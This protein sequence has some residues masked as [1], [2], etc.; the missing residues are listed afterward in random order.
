[1]NFADFEKAILLK[2]FA[3]NSSGSTI[4]SS[5]WLT[6]ARGLSRAGF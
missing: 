2:E 4:A 6:V 5:R 1:M 3:G